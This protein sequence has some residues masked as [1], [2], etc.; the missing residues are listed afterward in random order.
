MDSS[1]GDS[2]GVKGQ[3]HSASDAKLNDATR[4]GQ[5]RPRHG[6]RH[7]HPA[8][9]LFI[10]VLSAFFLF[11]L[12][13][14]PILPVSTSTNTPPE[15]PADPNPEPKMSNEQTYVFRHVSLLKYSSEEADL[16]AI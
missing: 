11:F 12:L 9:Y 15:K 13:P 7:R 2:S 1:H 16:C 5:Q 4:A 3:K 8:F 14:W 10:V 6:R